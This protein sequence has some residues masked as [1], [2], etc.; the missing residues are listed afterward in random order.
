MGPGSP[1]ASARVGRDDDCLAR[2]EHQPADVR[3]RDWGNF[4]C[5]GL[6]LTMKIATPTC[7][8]SEA[9]I[10]PNCH[11]RC[12]TIRRQSDVSA[13]V[14]IRCAAIRRHDVSP[15]VVISY[16]T[17]R[18]HN[19]FLLRSSHAPPP[20]P[21]KTFESTTRA[22]ASMSA[23]SLRRDLISKPIFRWAQ[24]VLPTL[25]DTEREAIEAG[26]VWWDADLFSGNPDWA[27]LL[28]VPPATL[29]EE[30]Q[31]FLDGPVDEFCRML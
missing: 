16:V 3:N 23:L 26:D 27:K 11:P 19:V 18:R 5:F 9:H 8:A 10:T 25:S 14:V 24:Q 22:E 21:Y 30:E 6:I 28:A 2:T 12:G 15:S 17:I 1:L 13:S 4:H 31:A 20:H 7:S 29:S